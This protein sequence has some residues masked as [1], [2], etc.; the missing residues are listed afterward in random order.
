MN[1]KEREDPSD[2]VPVSADELASYLGLP[3]W[4]ARV[5]RHRMRAWQDRSLE[6]AKRFLDPSLKDLPDPFSLVDMDR[7]AERVAEAIVQKESI[8]IY[9]DYDVDGT[10]GAA[11]L[12]RFFRSLGVEPAVYQPDRQTEGYGLNSAAV[13]SLAERGIQLLI[14]VDCGITSVKEVARANELGMDVVI[15]DHHEP[16]E[17]LPDAYAVLD[18]KRLDH[19]GPIRSLCGAGVA[20]YL[21]L[22][23]RSMLR[24]IDFF[25]GR[26]EPDLRKLLDLVAVAT[27]ADMVPL[28][29]ENRVLV[30]FG[31]EKLR[32]APTLGLAELL[33]AAEV[34]P[35]EVSPYHIGFLIG[36]RINASGRLDSANFALELLSTDDP[37]TARDLA[38]KLDGMNQDRKDL[39]TEVT[40]SALSQA[41]NHQ[42]NKLTFVLAG[43]DWHEGVI[44]IVASKVVEKHFRPTVMI[45]FQTHSG[46]G[47]GSVRSAGKVDVL[48]A[49]E[50][51]R[52]L[53]EGFGGHK[54]AAGLSIRR[55][56]L[57]SFRERFDGAVSAQVREMPGGI[58]EREL[59]LDAEI[60]GAG[61]LAAAHVRAMDRLAPFGIGNSEPVLA[62]KGYEVRSHRVMKE[63]HLKLSL[64]ADHGEIE[65]VWFNSVDRIDDLVK[66]SVD[67]AFVPQI[68]TFRNANNVQ[69]KIKDARA[70]SL[71]SS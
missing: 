49:L 58:L 64:T 55:E 2:L 60:T 47:K 56:N 30:V 24:D 18:H 48:A 1:W 45:T 8:A 13:E 11:L 23:V 39:Q 69:L 28:V 7:A 27:V 52:D 17:T 65:G 68:N 38:A 35:S 50:E 31:L 36:P 46:L 14:T 61:D 54:M 51:C 15:C 6:A 4:V 42:D 20:F 43:D 16:K 44:G 9:G 40:E 22:A 21:A 10:V 70:S 33:R 32:K 53:L 19:E 59:S 63:K 67:V 26:Q 57:D 3:L 62:L 66:G 37:E 34:N 29:E 12:R 71:S 41:A 5:M 25:E